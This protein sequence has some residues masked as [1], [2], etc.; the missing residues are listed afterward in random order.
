M[1]KY[2]NFLIIT[3]I[4]F[5]HSSVVCAQSITIDNANFA[6]T[7]YASGSDITLPIK[8]AGCFRYNNRFNLFLLD[9]SGN[10]TPLASINAFFTAFL[11]GKIPVGTIPGVQYRLRITSTNPVVTA[12]SVPFEIVAGTGTANNMVSSDDITNAAGEQVF[13]KCVFGET[14]T[15]YD[16]LL[17]SNAGGTFSYKLVDSNG[18]N[19]PI[20][21]VNAIQIKLNLLKGNYYTFFA[22]TTIASIRS[23]KAYLVLAS[24]SN[25]NLGGQGGGNEICFPASK[26]YFISS[27]G[28]ASFLLNYPGTYYTAV[29]GDNTPRDTLT[30]CDLV[31]ASGKLE[32]LY[33]SSS[34]GK[35]A[36]GGSG[37]IYNAFTTTITAA[38]AYC[39]N[40]DQITV[41]P[42]VFERPRANFVAPPYVCKGTTVK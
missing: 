19:V 12:T 33:N 24:T 42:K 3:S 32:H 7:G 31:A 40:F 22:T 16:V 21:P 10:S 1:G 25:L 5:F 6:T 35:V 8:L 26:S 38:N 41:Y 11:N 37:P 30:H 4:L 28:P 27:S 2:L 15:N 18:I 34:C 39:T 13:G 29:W 14:E 9:A 17:Q 20:T 23:V 36:Q